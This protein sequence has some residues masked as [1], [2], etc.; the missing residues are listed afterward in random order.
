MDQAYDRYFNEAKACVA[1]AAQTADLDAR[2]SLLRT[3]LKWLKLADDIA[4]GRE[5]LDLAL[6]HF[7]KAQMYAP[8]TDVSPGIRPASWPRQMPIDD[9]EYFSSRAE[10][11]RTG[12]SQIPTRNA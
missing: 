8:L 6:D 9:P 11:A 7:N 2:D 10:E 1:A 3:A 5:R 4:C 12:R